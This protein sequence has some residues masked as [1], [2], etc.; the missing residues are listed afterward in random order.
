M[1]SADLSN[2][3]SAI[4]ANYNFPTHIEE[5][6]SEIINGNLNRTKADSILSKHNINAGVAKVEFLDLLFEYIQCA[7]SDGILTDEEMYNIKY[8]K[9]CFRIQ[10]GDFQLHDKKNMEN[11][12]DFQL[13]HIY[14]DHLVSVIEA[15]LKTKLQEIFDLG[16]DDMNEYSKRHTL[17]LIQ[18]GID[19]KNLDVFFNNKEYFSLRVI[20]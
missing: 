5:I 18:N 19:S 17:Q 4:L 7:L 12:I 15:I 10:P 8:L 14:K 13:T 20:P 16:F 9:V 11:I 6:I 3:F 1:I 2:Q